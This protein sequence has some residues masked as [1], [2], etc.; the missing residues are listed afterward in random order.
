MAT[1]MREWVQVGRI[2]SKVVSYG[3]GIDT[4]P[5]KLVLVLPG[6]PGGWFDS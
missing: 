4:K 5:E 6:N 1:F 3:G 2:V